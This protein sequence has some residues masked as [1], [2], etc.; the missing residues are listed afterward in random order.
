MCVRESACNSL[1]KGGMFVFFPKERM[2]GGCEV[3]DGERIPCGEA[4]GMGGF[5]HF[6]SAA[7]L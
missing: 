2:E 4:N 6:K 5:A 3:H 7:A 1:R